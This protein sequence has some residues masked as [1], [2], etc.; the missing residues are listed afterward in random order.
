MHGGTGGDSHTYSYS[1]GNWAPSSGYPHAKAAPDS[2]AAALGRSLT[3]LLSEA[4]LTHCPLRTAGATRRPT[5]I[6]VYSF[7]PVAAVAG[8]LP[9]HGLDSRKCETS[10]NW[11]LPERGFV[12]SRLRLRL[13]RVLLPGRGPARNA[14][15]WIGVG[16]T[17]PIACVPRTISSK[18]P[19]RI[20]DAA[21][22]RLKE[23][24][25]IQC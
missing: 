14:R 1:H 9:R 23:L 2:R 15:S 13:R 8:G 21:T 7:G 24:P 5:K 6:S 10:Y 18:S 22:Q 12:V 17:N 25:K 11:W 20:K 3:N 19:K 16:S 4:H